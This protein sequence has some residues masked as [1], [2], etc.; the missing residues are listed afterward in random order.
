[1]KHR[2]ALFVVLTALLGAAN[3][4]YNTAYQPGRSTEATLAAVNGGAE[5]ARAVRVESTINNEVNLGFA[6]AQLLV[7]LACFAG[8]VVGGMARLANARHGA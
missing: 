2:I 8:P 4:Y 3:V 7:T 1:M 6:A 5:A